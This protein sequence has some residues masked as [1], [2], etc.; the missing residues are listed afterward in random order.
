M[1]PTPSTPPAT[2]E[3][4]QL[5]Y[6]YPFSPTKPDQLFPSLQL[7]HRQKEALWEVVGKTVSLHFATSTT[8]QY[9]DEEEVYSDYHGNT[10]TGTL[11]ALLGFGSHFLSHIVLGFSPSPGVSRVLSRQR[12]IPLEYQERQDLTHSY[13]MKELDCEQRCFSLTWPRVCWEDH[14]VATLVNVPSTQRGTFFHAL[15]HSYGHCLQN[16]RYDSLIHSVGPANPQ[17]ISKP[18][19]SR[20]CPYRFGRNDTAGILQQY[21]HRLV[22]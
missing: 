20:P 16:R 10:I 7:T 17:P 5:R 21:L 12:V 4:E 9:S 3:P 15:E 19:L 22:P 8:Y 2:T 13:L 14:D 1:K 6:I 18:S 11:Q